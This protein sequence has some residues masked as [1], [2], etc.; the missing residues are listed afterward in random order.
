MSP[1]T[2]PSSPTTPGTFVSRG[3]TTICEDPK[4]DSAEDQP[5]T[6]ADDYAAYDKEKGV[7]AQDDF[8]IDP[9]SLEK[10][11]T[12]RSLSDYAARVGTGFSN[13]LPTLPV[14]WHHNYLPEDRNSQRIDDHPEGYPRLAAL[15]NSDENFLIARRYGLLHARVMLY[16]QDELHELENELLALDAEDAEVDPRALK[17]R[18]RDDRREGQERK[19]LINAIDEKLKQYGQFNPWNLSL[20]S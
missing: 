17:S 5:Q 6:V 1:L 12:K 11:P 15:L 10:R 7:A 14:H 3:S 8:V 20:R 13:K 16:R 4:K 2:T 18:K 19:Q 9:E